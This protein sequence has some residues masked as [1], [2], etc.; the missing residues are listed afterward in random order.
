MR[1]LLAGDRP[2][3]R[4][5]GR[6]A[7]LRAGLECS[8]GDCVSLADLRLRLAREPDAHL[9]VVFLDPDP[10]AAARAIKA[11]AGQTRQPIYAVTGGAEGAVKDQAAAAGAAAVWPLERVREELLSSAEDLRRSGRI[12]DG[13]GRMISVVAAHAGAGVTTVATG[14]AFALT[15]DKPVCLAELGTGVPEM[16]LAL[17]LTPPHSLAEL[18]HERDRVDVSMLREASARHPLGVDVLA[19][20]PETLAPVPLGAD[21]A[22]DMQ[23]L[24]RSGYGWVVIDAGHAGETGAERL[25]CDSDAVVVVTRLD[26]PSLRLTRRFLRSLGEMGVREDRVVLAANRYGQAGLVPWRNAQDALRTTVA[27]WL[28]DDPKAVN[29]ALADG[30]PLAQAAR[31][32]RLT[33]ALSKLAAELRTRLA[34]A[35]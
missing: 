18:I 14:L 27:A 5:Q 3:D 9:V 28:P 13:R 34:P 4:D 19:Y 17:D 21:G 1:V 22:R 30:R 32:G 16:A 23:I 7:A 2:N 15:G 6:H 24:L 35:R 11:A 12:P 25:V 31:G 26:P 20:P 29:K 10:A 8:S 33:R